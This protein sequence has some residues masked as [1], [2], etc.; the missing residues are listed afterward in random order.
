M[1]NE[2]RKRFVFPSGIAA[3]GEIKK[4]DVCPKANER[5]HSF[6]EIRDIPLGD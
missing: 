3:G 5:N 6:A 1:R 2:P 4:T